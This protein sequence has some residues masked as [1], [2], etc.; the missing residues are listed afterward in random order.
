MRYDIFKMYMEL[1]HFSW[2]W[3]ELRSWDGSV[4]IVVNCGLSDWALIPGR[5]EIC[6]SASQ[7]P[8]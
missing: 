5:G 1:L 4:N 8:D 6:I 7:W 2:Y 3:Y